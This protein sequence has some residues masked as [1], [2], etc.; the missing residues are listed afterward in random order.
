M[1]NR[2]LISAKLAELADRVARVRTCRTSTETELKGD[3]NAAEL[4]AFNLML[5]VQICADIASHLIADE[6]WS[7]ART[8]GEG[9]ARLEE[10]QVIPSDV[11]AALR[12]AVGLRNVVAHG[13][14]GVDLALLHLAATR[15]VDDLDSFARSIAGW[16][17]QQG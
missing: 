2:T 4:V 9:F 17:M 16:V 12:N 8:I 7:V 1:V 15:G 5:A 14:A 13:Y 3:R 10:H 6:G 11:A